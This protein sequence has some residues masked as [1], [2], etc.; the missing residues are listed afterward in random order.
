MLGY[1]ADKVLICGW[2]WSVS[3]R[4]SLCL[5]SMATGPSSQHIVYVQR[6]QNDIESVRFQE[7]NCIVVC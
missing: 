6:M 1:F 4:L 7:Y 3:W 2:M 5:G